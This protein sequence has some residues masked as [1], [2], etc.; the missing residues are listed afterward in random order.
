[1]QTVPGVELFGL[2]SHWNSCTI[3]CNSI[4]PLP[5]RGFISTCCWLNSLSFIFF[6]LYNP[7]KDLQMHGYECF[8]GVL[9]SFLGGSTVAL[10]EQKQYLYTIVM[11]HPS[12]VALGSLSLHSH[13][14]LFCW[15]NRW[16][17]GATG[18]DHPLQQHWRTH[19][20]QTTHW[21]ALV[22]QGPAALISALWD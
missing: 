20:V 14:Y 13:K 4:E 12:Q 19:F 22:L 7:S 10:V 11:K 1:M 2:G 18:L 8:Q 16:T 5:W 6:P 3:F 9:Q 15:I 17:C 21:H